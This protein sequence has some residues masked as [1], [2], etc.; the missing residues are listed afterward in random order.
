MQILSS[1]NFDFVRWRWHAIALSLAVILAGAATIWTKGL[2]LGVDFAGGSIVIVK[3]QQETPA[4]RVR[5]AIA[6]MPNGVGND[7]VV[8][9]YGTPSEHMMLIRI[10]QTA[11]QSSE[12]LSQD[13]DAVAAALKGANIGEFEVVG[14][15]I[16]GPVVGQ[17]LKKQGLLATAF[18]LAG[19]LIY[20]ALRFQV[21][22][23]VGAIAATLH[24]LLICIAFLAFFRYDLTLNVIAG[25][26]G[27]FLHSQPVSNRELSLP[28]GDKVA[29]HWPSTRQCRRLLWQVPLQI[30]SGRAGFIPHLVLLA[31]FTPMVTM[32]ASLH[33][34]A[35]GVW[36]TTVVL[37]LVL[38]PLL[39]FLGGVRRSRR[40]IVARNT[41]MNRFWYV[42]CAGGAPRS[43]CSAASSRTESMA[44]FAEVVGA[45]CAGC[46]SAGV[47]SQLTTIT[48]ATTSRAEWNKRPSMNIAIP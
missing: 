2:P 20:I 29:R 45:C 24:D 46:P 5:T 12:N 42:S 38:W 35:L 17:Q 47:A 44:L 7:A 28:S 33:I 22:F 40:K 48:A 19:I 39:A 13:A 21:S 6:S 18:A 10:A 15:E 32:R 36:S 8:Q 3:F 27:A 11:A 37:F 34:D 30:M 16:V 31:V 41:V 23:A 25:G 4:E 26:G 1:T 43:A 9:Q 14:T